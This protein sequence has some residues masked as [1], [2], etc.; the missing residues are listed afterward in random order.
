M[1][2]TQAELIAEHFQSATFLIDPDEAGRKLARRAM[3]A[4]HGRILVKL[5]FP[6]MQADQMT[7]KEM[8]NYLGKPIMEE[9]CS[10]ETDS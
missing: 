1:S 3:E 9:E 4:L 8:E 5:I 7:A 10:D 6:P 2:Y